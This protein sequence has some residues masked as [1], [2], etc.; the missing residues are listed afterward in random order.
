MIIFQL[1][2]SFSRNESFTRFAL[3]ASQCYND[4]I[5]R[6]MCTILIHNKVIRLTCNSTHD[7]NHLLHL[8]IHRNEQLFQDV[9]CKC[10][11]ALVDLLFHLHRF[12]RQLEH[13]KNCAKWNNYWRNEWH[14][15]NVGMM[16][17]SVQCNL[18]IHAFW[19]Y[20]FSFNQ[21]M[22]CCVGFFADFFGF[23]IHIYYINNW[24]DGALEEICKK[25]CSHSF[26][27]AFWLT[28]LWNKKK[29]NFQLAQRRKKW[30]G[31]KKSRVESSRFKSSHGKETQLS[32]IFVSSLDAH[33]SGSLAL[34][35][36]I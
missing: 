5:K 30:I 18:F 29:L 23:L 14:N 8:Y 34:H 35:P 9:I 26:E 32:Y 22:F 25:T 12:E 16:W 2:L 15:G 27:Y 31:M 24:T 36:Y 20:F 28:L 33:R 1:T 19:Y 13:T 21:Q 6:K 7:I 17:N 10:I 4:A 11:V 3:F